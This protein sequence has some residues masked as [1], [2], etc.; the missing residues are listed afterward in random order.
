MVLEVPVL[1]TQHLCTMPAAFPPT[2][3]HSRHR[4]ALPT[5]EVE[6]V[7]LMCELAAR[8]H[9]TQETLSA[10]DDPPEPRPRAPCGRQSSMRLEMSPTRARAALR[11]ALP[12]RRASASRSA[13]MLAGTHS[14]RSSALRRASSDCAAHRSSDSPSARRVMYACIEETAM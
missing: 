8:H 11:A 10:D 6:D 12:S 4:R 9:P 3:A 2:A 14:A 13:F 5:D 1:E 7:L